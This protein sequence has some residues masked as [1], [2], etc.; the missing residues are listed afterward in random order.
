MRWIDKSVG[1]VLVRLFGRLRRPGPHLLGRVDTIVVSKYLG[2]GSLL[3]ATPLLQLLRS[4]FPKARIIVVSFRQN[5]AL[6]KSFPFVDAIVAV[7][8]GNLLA[9]TVSTIRAILMLRALNVDVWFDLEFFVRYS[10]VV[11]FLSRAN[12]RVGFTAALNRRVDLLTHAVSFN[13]RQHVSD[14]F[15]DQAR[16]IGLTPPARREADGPSIYRLTCP[17]ESA[18]RTAE[19]LNAQK[20]SEFVVFNATAGEAIGKERRWPAE[21][22]SELADVVARRLGLG[23]VFTGEK[24]SKAEIDAMVKGCRSRGVHNLAGFTDFYGFVDTIS[25]ARAV[26]TIDSAALHIARSIGTPTVSL[27]GPEPPLVHAYPGP[28]NRQ[29]YKGYNGG[30]CPCFDLFE[31]KRVRCRYSNACMDAISVSEVF[32]VL[33]DLVAKSAGR[34]VVS[35]RG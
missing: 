25:K 13:A 3:M 21:R 28:A 26:V 11:T 10:A 5:E 34:E 27:H 22:W 1:E 14:T 15:L 8:R 20:I 17:L 32:G 31:N 19:I 16:A 23:V 18:Q 2:I 24:T 4:R 35:T 9:F 6:L 33:A 30:P 7:D 29:V 12:I